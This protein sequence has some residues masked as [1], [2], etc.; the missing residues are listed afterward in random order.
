[1]NL[2]AKLHNELVHHR[3][4]RI[5]AQLLAERIPAKA[6][7]LDV[8][9]GDGS[10]ASLIAQLRPDVTIRGVEVM[11]RPGCK[12]QCEPYDGLH[13]PFEG[14]SLEVCMMVD[15]L[16]HTDDVTI[17]LKE[18][19]RVSNSIVLLRDHLSENALDHFTLKALDWAGNRPHDVRL[20]YNYQSRA[21]WDSAF[22]ESGLIIENWSSKASTYLPPI[23]WV[24]GRKLHFIAVLRKKGPA[25]PGRADRI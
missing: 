24:A 6:R 20:T 25:E 23:T 13:L 14:G 5:T 4:V 12:V 19:S 15:V 18:A 10:I 17:L 21:M 9:C 11:P 16:H 2:F 1:M 3:R 7:V 22:A 8:G